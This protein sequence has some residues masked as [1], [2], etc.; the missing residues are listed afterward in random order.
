MSL[1]RKVRNA[2]LSLNH[3]IDRIS[4]SKRWIGGGV[5]L[6]VLFN[7]F[8][9]LIAALITGVIGWSRFTHVAKNS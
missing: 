4:P 8:P 9:F 3:K 1:Q 7:L 2:K 5:V 6:L